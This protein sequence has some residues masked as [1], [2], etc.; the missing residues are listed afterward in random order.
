MLQNIE[1]NNPPSIFVCDTSMVTDFITGSASK[2]EIHN[3]IK[4]GTI[5]KLCS[6]MERKDSYCLGTAQ[7][8]GLICAASKPLQITIPSM[9]PP[10]SC[11]Q[12][13]SSGIHQQHGAASSCPWVAQEGGAGPHQAPLLSRVCPTGAAL[14][15]T[16]SPGHAGGAARSERLHLHTG[17]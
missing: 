7:S 1:Q 10:G 2:Q 11:A 3:S 15:H 14:P 6:L 12:Q 9:L 16:P 5:Q 17:L 8:R 13:Y 4:T